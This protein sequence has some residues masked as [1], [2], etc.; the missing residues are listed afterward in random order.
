VAV[1]K[2][3]WLTALFYINSAINA[4]NHTMLLPVVPANRVARGFDLA[5]SI[6]LLAAGLALSWRQAEEPPPS[7]LGN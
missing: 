7:L 6:G 2:L 4:V 3:I 1:A 5:I